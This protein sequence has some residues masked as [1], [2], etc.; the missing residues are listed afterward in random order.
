MHSIQL[1]FIGAELPKKINKIFCRQKWEKP[2]FPL[3]ILGVRYAADIRFFAKI[4]NI[5][6]M[7]LFLNLLK[8]IKNT[9]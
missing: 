1:Y 9:I 3:S 6:V 7:F 2:I 5:M 8:G 4:G